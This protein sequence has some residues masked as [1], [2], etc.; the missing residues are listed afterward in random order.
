MAKQ[1]KARVLT[2]QEHTQFL[3]FLATSRQA[4]LNKA[5]YLLGYRAGLRVGSIAG[6]KI[7]DVLDSSGNLKEVVELR[8]DIVKNRKNYAAYLTHPELRE[9]L[10]SYLAERPETEVENLFVSQKNTGFSAN[11]LTHK[12][13]KLY[14]E[15][16][17]DGASSHSGRRSFATNCIRSGVDIVSLKT[18]MNH[19]SIQQTSEYIATNEDMLKKAVMGV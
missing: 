11:A 19:A 12:M 6:I 18:L 7:N 16:G 3:Q 17:F 15:A 2:T 4:A 8:R 14:R 13:L 9:A 10:L 1:G 5:V